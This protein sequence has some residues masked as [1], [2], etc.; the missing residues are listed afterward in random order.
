MIENLQIVDNT[1]FSRIKIYPSGMMDIILEPNISFRVQVAVSKV[2][3][4]CSLD[5]FLLCE[6]V[7][8]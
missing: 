1:E 8:R 5:L 2:Y 7:L 4:S 3:L 6:P